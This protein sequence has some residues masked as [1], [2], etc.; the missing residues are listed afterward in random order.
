MTIGDSH[1]AIMRSICGK[2]TEYERMDL[3]TI[4]PCF[5]LF[6]PIFDRCFTVDLHSSLS[7]HTLPKSAHQYSTAG[8]EQS[9]TVM[10]RF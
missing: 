3:L 8:T 6:L 7:A 9:F 4:L 5:S 10:Y 2:W 1:G